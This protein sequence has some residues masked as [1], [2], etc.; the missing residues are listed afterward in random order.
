MGRKKKKKKK[1]PQ[2]LVQGKQVT[3]VPL[4]ISATKSRFPPI[5][6]SSS[7]EDTDDANRQWWL[8]ER[9]TVDQYKAQW[10]G[11]QICASL[12][13]F[14]CFFSFPLPLRAVHVPART[15]SKRQKKLKKHIEN[16]KQHTQSHHYYP[17]SLWTVGH[18]WFSCSLFFFVSF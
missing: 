18:S 3:I 8:D 11:L 10:R 7:T 6:G 16:G 9:H 4:H 14:V 15:V 2:K 13:V 12:F 5:C 17:T 1:N